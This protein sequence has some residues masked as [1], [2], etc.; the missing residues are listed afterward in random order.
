MAVLAR[1]GKPCCSSLWAGKVLCSTQGDVW[2]GTLRAEDFPS[3]AAPS[4]EETWCCSSRMVQQWDSIFQTAGV[5]Q[6]DQFP[7]ANWAC[8]LPASKACIWPGRFITINND[9]SPRAVRADLRCRSLTLSGMMLKNH[10]YYR[11]LCSELTV[12]LDLVL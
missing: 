1:A 9:E 4:V 11:L 5:K 10:F 2:W 12:N 6:S 8:N 3:L 7:W